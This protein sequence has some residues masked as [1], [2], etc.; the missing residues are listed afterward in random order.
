MPNTASDLAPAITFSLT[1]DKIE[2]IKRMENEV[3]N[4]KYLMNKEA[5]SR[6]KKH[7]Y[8]AM[9]YMEAAIEIIQQQ[10]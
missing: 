7:Y 4:I 8:A 9:I 1:I 5:E 10:S 2:L 6:K 3:L